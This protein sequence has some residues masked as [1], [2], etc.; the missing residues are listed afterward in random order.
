MHFLQKSNIVKR[1]KKLHNCTLFILQNWFII[2]FFF[3]KI[4]CRG[5]GFIGR[6]ITVRNTAGPQNHQAVALRSGSDLSVFYQCSFE[7]YQD[8]LYVHSNRQFY[9]E[10]D[11][12]GTVDFILAMRLW[13]FKIATFTPVTRLTRQTL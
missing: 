7:G 11:I 9:R 8:T 2:L 12:Y 6:G 5:D 3:Y 10:C 13:S 4:S 1:E